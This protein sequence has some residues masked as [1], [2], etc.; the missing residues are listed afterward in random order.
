MNKNN[1]LSKQQ[2]EEQ[3]RK[4]RTYNPNPDNS[5]YP[6]AISHYKS[7]NTCQHIEIIKKYLFNSHYFECKN[8]GKEI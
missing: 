8:C 1:N 4:R 7:N 5:G 6:T 2:L 3:A